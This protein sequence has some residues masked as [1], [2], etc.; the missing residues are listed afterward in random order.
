M[1]RLLLIYVRL[2]DTLEYLP[3]QYPESVYLWTLT[4]TT[5]EFC[6][7]AYSIYIEL[8]HHH[9]KLK[10]AVEMEEKGF[11]LLESLEQKQTKVWQK[12]RSSFPPTAAEASSAIKLK[13]GTFKTN[14]S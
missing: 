2:L 8:Q 6:V 13:E 10:S 12:R 9:Q 3:Q 7:W 5:L 1:E 4:H 14:Q 11:Q